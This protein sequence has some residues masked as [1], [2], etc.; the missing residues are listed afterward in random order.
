MMQLC[1]VDDF[2][3]GVRITTHCMY[4]SNGL[5]RVTINGGIE[6]IV[7]SD[8]GEAFGEA[9]AAGIEISNPD[10]LLRG[11][12]KER[13]LLLKNGIIHTQMLPMEAA[14][15]A[16][17]HVANV[18]KEAAA[19]LYNHGGL[20][21]KRDFRVLL[22]KFL[23]S[24]FREQVAED[25]LIGASHKPHKFPHV[26]SFSNGRKFIVDAVSNDP[27]SINSRVVANM[28]IRATNDPMIDQRIVYD[29]AEPWNSSDLNLLQ[30]GATIVPF[31]KAQDVIQL[32][33]SE[34]RVASEGGVRK[35][36]GR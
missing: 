3:N 10:K 22:S 23:T 31:S 14:P 20:K 18:A 35:L 1:P 36:F 19:W 25:R 15:V 11:F 5:V 30:V 16:I 24:E 33:A 34:A 27:S 2:E 17:L 6:K 4:P 32:V 28:D 13:G 7:V 8:G 26:I 21:S 12:I 29:D 9:L